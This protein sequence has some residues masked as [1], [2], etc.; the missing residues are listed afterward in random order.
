MSILEKIENFY[1]NQV[2]IIKNEKNRIIRMKLVGSLALDIGGKCISAI[3]K[4]IKCSRKFIRKSITFVKNGYKE[5]LKL[6][7]RGRKSLI[8]IYPELEADIVKI[9]E[10][11][12][13]T[14]PRFK[15]EK[16]YVRLTVKEIKK[17][18]IE[19]GKYEERSFSNSS[20]NNILNKMGYNLKKVKK[21]EP[22][23]R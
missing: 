12:L 16:Q 13:S 22:L 21:T 17:Q 23:K 19:T 8:T 9:I 2:E 7:F 1:T 10:D 14:D 15:T 5:Q 18:L 20:L 6:E 3:S 11:S 4:V